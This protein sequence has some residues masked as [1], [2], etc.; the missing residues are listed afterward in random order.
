MKPMSSWETTSAVDTLEKR[1]RPTLVKRALKRSGVVAKP[2]RAWIIEGMPKMGDH[3]S[4]YT[5]TRADDGKYQCTCQGHSG[6]QYRHTCSHILYVILAGY[7]KVEF[8]GVLED[9]PAPPKPT[10]VETPEIP[11]PE[12]LPEDPGDSL[13]PEIDAHFGQGLPDWLEQLRP[14]QW[15]AVAEIENL[16][17]EGKKVVFLDAPTGAGK[18]LIGELVRRRIASKRCI[19]GCVTKTLQDQFLRDYP[20][21][22]IIKGRSNY[23]TGNW[24]TRFPKISAELC[25]LSSGECTIGEC[26]MCTHPALC[27]YHV[28]KA[29]ARR[30]PLAVANMAYLLSV[31]NY[32]EDFKDAPL[33][34]L[35]EADVLEE[36]LM[37]F[38]E[39]SF[40]SRRLSQMGVGPPERKTVED[41]WLV[42]I[43]DKATPA[44]KR[45]VNKLQRKYREYRDMEPADKRAWNYWNGALTKLYRMGGWDPIEQEW[46]EDFELENWVYTGYNEHRKSVTFKPVKV[47]QIAPEYLWGWGQRFLLMSAT[48]ISAEQM[49]EDLGLEDNEW[50]VVT[51]DSTFPPERRPIYVESVANMT[52]KEK[53]IAWPTMADRIAEIIQHHKEDRILVHTVSY[54]FAQYLASRLIADGRTITY[55]NARERENALQRFKN[56]GNGVVLAPSFDRGVDLPQDECRVV[57][58]AKVP[59]P[60]LGDKQVSRRL[61]SRG[62]KNWYAMLTARTLVQMTGRAMR[63]EDD[64]CEIYLLD[65][66]FSTKVRKRRGLL[67]QWWRDAIVM[68]SPIKRGTNE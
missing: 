8:A 67:P 33:V 12:P 55:R 57:I 48:I 6:G 9:R 14:H 52:H 50:G 13:R 26:T 46:K 7:G 34:I 11:F 58:V 35:D 68:G 19:Y 40:S 54:A 60:N 47:N 43:R 51:V 5:V 17:V 59:Y 22:D 63:S 66:Q 39:I 44:V 62:G 4:E 10:L 16:F 65:K 18:T 24:P 25:D 49:A 30:S 1:F 27:E 61:Y 20:Y 32:Q 31:W 36:E 41:A 37:R 64:S 38:V 3:Y 42:W 21:A 23:P 56:S 45:E 2:D 15:K 29:V 53:D 28:A